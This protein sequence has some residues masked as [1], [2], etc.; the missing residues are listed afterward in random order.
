MPDLDKD[1]QEKKDESLLEKGKKATSKFAKIKKFLPIIKFALFFL[2]IIAGAIVVIGLVME[3][4]DGVKDLFSGGDVATIDPQT[5]EIIVDN[6]Q[7]D[8]I[9]NSIGEMGVDLDGLKLMGDKADYNDPEVEAKNKEASRKYIKKF[10]EAQVVTETLNYNKGSLPDK[11]YGNVYVNRTNE[12]ATDSKDSYKLTHIDY[13]KM[14]KMAEDGD[15][16]IRKYFSINDKGE[17]VVAGWTHTVIKEDKTKVSDETNIVLKNINYKAAISQYTTPAQFFM[18]LAIVSQN[19]EFAAAVTDLVK[20]GKIDITL[21]DNVTKNVTTET[22]TCT[23]HTKT[24]TEVE[25]NGVTTLEPDTSSNDI[26]K[27]TETTTITTSPLIAI[28]HVK[29]W[30]CEQD[31]T[32]NKVE[33]QTNNTNTITQDDEPEPPLTG[34]GSVSWKTDQQTVIDEDILTKKFEEGVRGDVIDRTGEKRDGKE[35]F[36]GLLDE[37]FKI[38]N[39]QRKE[40]AGTN[41]VSGAELLFNLLQRDESMQ[42]LEQV[43]RYILYKYTGRDYGVTSLDFSIYDIKDFKSVGGGGSQLL[44]EYIHYWE[45]STPPPTNADGT[46]YIIEDDGAGNA[47]VGYGIDIINGGFKDLFIQAGYPITVGGEVDKDFVDSLEEQEIEDCITGIKAATSGIDLT[48]YQLNALVSRAYNCG[49]AGAVDTLRGSPSLNFANSYNKYW[50]QERDDKFEAQDSNA[51]FSHSLY[52]Q[53]MSKPVTAK[54]YGYMAGLEKRRKSEWTLFQT[55]YYDVL[56][57]WHMSGGE[58]IEW[59]DTIHKYMEQNNYT[60]CVYGGNSY[61]ECGS[62]GKAHGLDNTFEKSKTNHQN[63]CCATYV[64]WVLQEAGYITEEEHAANGLNGANNL[65]N[66]LVNKGF[67]VI[68]DINQLEPGDILSYDGHIEIY[69]GDGAVY[70]AGS[71]SAIRNASPYGKGVSGIN[72]AL[73]AP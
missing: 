27:E 67:T 61:E 43:M 60:Y 64:S 66:F 12:N 23:E 48:G 31:I 34:P 20:D 37:P 7:I 42:N 32:Y 17:L 14:K 22:Y 63:T 11:T 47:V 56:N 49:K 51:D 35:S 65:A 68:T 54:N 36:I 13:E 53:Y 29:T 2:L 10:Y 18:C 52:T 40:I 5:G 28:T 16:N 4:V 71:G 73:R 70:N 44:K 24:K 58:I 57:K 38:P 19:P 50:D 72:K 21:M 3:V 69:A 15:T 6:N 30:F 45:H 9:I 62:Y 55:G 46:K 59:A 39:V 41:I 33:N 26:K 8:T 1:N 25:E